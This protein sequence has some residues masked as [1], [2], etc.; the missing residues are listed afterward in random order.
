MPREES[1]AFHPQKNI[2][3]TLLGL[4]PVIR[5]DFQEAGTGVLSPPSG[6]LPPSPVVT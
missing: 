5:G 2:K 4:N 1:P 3:S 6:R